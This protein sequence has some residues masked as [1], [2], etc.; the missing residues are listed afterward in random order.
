MQVD[1]WLIAVVA[2]SLTV[3]VGLLV[4]FTVRGQR[5]RVTTGREGMIG[6][7]AMVKVALNPRGKVLVDGELWTADIDQGTAQPG[8]E[9]VIKRV[10]NLKLLVQ[11]KQ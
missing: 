7:A 3:F 4:W 6:Q 5:G 1:G 9:V 2:A 11:K 10:D 8:E